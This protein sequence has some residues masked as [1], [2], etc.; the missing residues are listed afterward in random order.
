MGRLTIFAKGN[1]DIRDSLHS[2][3]VNGAIVWNGVGP[4]ARERHPVWTTRVRHE[5]FTRSDAL[6][7]A[8]GGVPAELAE[9]APPL[10]AYPPQSQF[11]GAI[12]EGDADA[13]V[14]SIQPDLN[15]ALR[16]HR[17][18]GWVFYPE[19]QQR[20]SPADRAWL[21]Q[22]FELSP[23]PGAEAAMASLSRVIERIRARSAAPILVY[24]LSAA[25]PGDDVHLHRGLGETLATRIRRFNLALTE[26]SARAG[27]SIIDVDRIV[28]R[29]GA[30]RL[31]L[32]ALHL[33]AE[34][35]RRV[36]EEVVRVLTDW[37]CFA[38]EVGP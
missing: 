29:G 12:F 26:L 8:E 33:S 22:S 31:K 32:D 19:G 30:D 38:D 24:N 4:V 27:V 5:T 14:L 36:A 6:A 21:A 3:R 15:T 9:R 20:W 37:G 16:R 11:S 2:M 35:C 25:I 17:R 10:G 23:P 7:A 34:G 18:D 13:Y 1:L 28:A